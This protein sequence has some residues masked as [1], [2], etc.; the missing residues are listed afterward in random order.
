MFLQI[1]IFFIRAL[2][3]QM[4]C[5]QE[6]KHEE[7]CHPDC[8][9][10]TAKTNPLDNPDSCNSIEEHRT[11]ISEGVGQSGSFALLQRVRLSYSIELK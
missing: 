11:P 3:T 2:P 8:G 10:G 7:M 5:V 9:L 4:I 1:Y 6:Q